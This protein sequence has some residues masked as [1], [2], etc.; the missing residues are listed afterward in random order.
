[1][2]KHMSIASKM[3]ADLDK[4]IEKDGTDVILQNISSSVNTFYGRTNTF[5]NQTVR[6]FIITKGERERILL[7]GGRLD[8]SIIAYGNSSGNYFP[9]EVDENITFQSK[10]WSIKEVKPL[11]YQGTIIGY[12]YGLVRQ[13]SKG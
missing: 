12:R 8:G 3:K 9:L 6:L 4:R 2:M 7:S 11:T 1:M 5:E 10:E 13:K